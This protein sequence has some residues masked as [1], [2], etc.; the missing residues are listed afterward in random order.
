MAGLRCGKTY[1]EPGCVPEGGMVTV[2][3]PAMLPVPVYTSV[4]VVYVGGVST[5]LRVSNVSPSVLQGSVRLKPTLI[6][7]VC[8]M[9]G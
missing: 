9:V 5:I 4:M 2:V 7:V 6:P 1:T 8:P 3:G